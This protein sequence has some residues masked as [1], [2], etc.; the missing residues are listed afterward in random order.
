[1]EKR[2]HSRDKRV[3]SGSVNAQSG[4]RVDTNGPVGNGGRTPS[5]GNR[6][7]QNVNRASSGGILSLFSALP[8]G[9]KKILLIILAIIVVFFLIKSCS[10]GFDV[11]ITPDDPIDNPG[12]IADEEDDGKIT[13]DGKA[14][15]KYVSLKGNGND[16]VTIMVYMCG[17]DLESKYGM[18][19]SDLKEMAA[20]NLSDKINIIVET[21]GCS[22]WKIKGISNTKNQIYQVT[23]QGLIPREQD[24]GTLAMTEPTNLTKFI[25]YCKSYYEADRYILIFWD[26]GGGTLSGYGYDEVRQSSSMTLPKINSAIGAALENSKVKFDIIGFDACLMATFETALVCDQYA[27]YLIASEETEPGTGWYYTTW[28][29]KLSANTSIDT[30]TLAKTIID[31]YVS[32]CK[33]SKVTLSVTD[34]AALHGKIP[35]AF[36][37][38]SESTTE[39]IKGEDYK[40]VSNARAN[41][42][43]FSKNINQVD[44]VDLATRIGT[45]DSKK[46]AKAIKECVIYNGSTISNANGLSIYFP[47]ET[48]SGMNNA[49]NLYN[50]LGLDKDYVN[51]IKSFASLEASG[52]IAA[53]TSTLSSLGSG[54]SILDL[55]LNSIGGGS[56]ST[57]TASPVTSLLGGLLNSSGTAASGSSLDLGTVVSLLSSL[58]GRSMPDNMAWFDTDIAESSAAQISQNMLDPGRIFFTEKNGK[59]VLKLTDAEWDLIQSVELN[60][61]VD[62]NGHYIDLGYDNTIDFD[63]DGDLVADYD[64]TWLTVDGHLV[65]YYMVSD[66]ENSDGSYTTIGYIPALLND[67][68]VEIGVVFDNESPYGRI[69]GAKPVYGNETDTEAKGE[70]TIE[71]GDSIQPICDIYGADGSYSSSNK[72]GKAF[73]ADEL[74]LANMRL[75]NDS[76]SVTYRIKDIY[77]NIFFTP[78]LNVSAE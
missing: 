58:S 33:G 68:R 56:T 71:K 16:T 44:L 76:V 8:S 63:A 28:L 26:H 74:Y 13:V 39:M 4:H 38:F 75:T 59:N 35:E 25:N 17:T 10:G 57:T 6:S 46:L 15:D 2:P 60:V 18:A 61:Y 77:G 32:S 9:I 64:Y 50:G 66:T 52:Q 27:D 42:R 40:V 21:G 36:S 34:L 70:I 7:S 54:S 67:E 49:V 41:T 22:Q 53:S 37:D 78:A 23:S 24:F 45:S 20:A 30:P 19:T 51:C 43:Q 3:S 72:L 31:S 47:Y 5:G 11:P 62:E 29:N 48:T 14:R 55:V 1:M 73:K 65:A 12:Y 69:T